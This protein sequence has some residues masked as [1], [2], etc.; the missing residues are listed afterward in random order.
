LAFI[1]SKK[2]LQGFINRKREALEVFTSRASLC[3]LSIVN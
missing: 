1:G 2:K 3:K